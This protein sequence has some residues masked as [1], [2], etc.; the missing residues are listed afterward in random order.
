MGLR[1]AFDRRLKLEANPTPLPRSVLFV[2]PVAVP[3]ARR[4]SPVTAP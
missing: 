4:R 3:Y 2:M 1:V